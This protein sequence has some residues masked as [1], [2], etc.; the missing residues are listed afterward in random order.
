MQSQEINESIIKRIN[1]GDEKAFS[2]LYQAYYV[3]LNVYAVS[4]IN[5]K[6]VSREI[7]NDIF[8][9]IWNKRGTLTYP[10]YSYLI[11]AVQNGSI[12][13]L[14]SQ[15]SLNQVL[16]NHKEQTNLFFENY[17]HSTPEP[18]QDLEL[19][20][21]E[22]E[23]Q[24]ALDQLP[25]RCRDIFKFYFYEGKPI[26][27]IAEDLQIQSSTVRVQLKNSLGKLRKMLEHLLLFIF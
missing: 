23:I 25:P 9:Q 18:L 24:K 17:I 5:D 15:N 13:Y 4:Y 21:L 6:N 1:T 19:R 3:Q 11:K 10:I 2:I 20:Q 14:R 12:D 22:E 26:K 8:L 7:V 27:E 16:E